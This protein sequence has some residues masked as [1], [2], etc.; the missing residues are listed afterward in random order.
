MNYKTLNNLQQCL[1]KTFENHPGELISSIKTQVKHQQST[2]K[3]PQRM[4]ITNNVTAW[5][6]PEIFRY[7]NYGLE[8]H[9]TKV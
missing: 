3:N 1:M 5:F 4:R 8:T 7:F 2:H 6:V 9:T